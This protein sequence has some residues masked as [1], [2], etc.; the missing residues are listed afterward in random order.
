MQVRQ[1]K[2]MLYSDAPISTTFLQNTVNYEGEADADD[3]LNHASIELE[4][5]RSFAGLARELLRDAFKTQRHTRKSARDPVIGTS[6][7]NN[8]VSFVVTE[9]HV[10]IFVSHLY[11]HTASSELID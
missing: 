6:T 7:A 8:H 10:D 1:L 5:G 3:P 11:P 9:R 4:N 2:A